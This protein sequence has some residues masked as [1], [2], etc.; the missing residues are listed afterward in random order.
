MEFS[1]VVQRLTGFKVT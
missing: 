1:S